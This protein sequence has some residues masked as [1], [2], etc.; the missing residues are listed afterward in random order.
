MLIGQCSPVSD[1]TVM[2]STGA[3]CNHIVH[4]MTQLPYGI[5]VGA[6]AFVGFLFGGLT[7]QY[8]LSIGVTAVVLYTALFIATKVFKGKDTELEAA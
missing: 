6:S 8:V 1:T 2:S 5:M 7:G 3:S 4:V